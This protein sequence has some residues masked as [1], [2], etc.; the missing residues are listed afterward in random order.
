LSE[1]FR[2]TRPDVIA[3]ILLDRKEYLGSARTFSR[4]M[5][6]R[7]LNA[8]RNKK[9]TSKPRKVPR[10]CAKGPNEVWSW[11]ITYLKTHVKG[12]YF[13]LYL[14]MDIYSRKIVGWSIHE[15]ESA[16]LASHVVT[17][18]KISENLSKDYPLT[19][20]SDNGSPMKGSTML[21]TLQS[22]N[23][24]PSNSRPS[25][26]ND[27]AYSE[28]LFATVKGF[29]SYPKN[30]FSTIEK[31]R[32][33]TLA[34]TDWYN[35]KHYHSGLNYIRPVDRHNMKDEEILQEREKVIVEAKNKN[36]ERWINDI[37]RDMK[38]KTE[39]YINR[40]SEKDVA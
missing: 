20:H 21:S 26:S 7:N 3:N 16:F 37:I 10:L 13:F 4:V 31:G 27:N 25:V 17:D 33:W 19:L 24:A 8:K 9:K 30:G 34:F 12:M 38:I 5:K 35:N 14:I 18:A 2:D 6:E 32:I 28:S 15:S 36:P 1:E 23:I 39:V 22:L 40:K 11:D 29:P